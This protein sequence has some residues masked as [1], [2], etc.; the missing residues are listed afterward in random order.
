[1]IGRMADHLS[2]SP[3]TG[4]SPPPTAEPVGPIELKPRLTVRIPAGML[5]EVAA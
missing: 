3:I 1:V 2:T 4:S 5:K